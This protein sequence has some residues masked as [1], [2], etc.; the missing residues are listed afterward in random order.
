MGIHNE[1]GTSKLPLGTASDLVGNM[2][3]KIVDT[4]DADRGFVPFKHD[5]KDEVVLLVND[6]GAVS[7]LEMS[8]ITNEGE[9]DLCSTATNSLE[10]L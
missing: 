4:T 2:L 6:L 10:N 9:L 1:P 8:G 5:G 3:S 7:E